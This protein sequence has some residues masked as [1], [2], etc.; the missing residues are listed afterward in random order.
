MAGSPVTI[1]VPTLHSVPSKRKTEKIVEVIHKMFLLLRK[2]VPVRCQDITIYFSMEEWQYI[3]AHKDLYKG[4]MMENQTSRTSQDGS[5]NEIPP[6]RCVGP[7]YSLDCQQ[8][9]PTIPHHYQSEESKDIKLE[10]KMEEADMYQ[11][12]DQQSTE[13]DNTMVNVKL[14]EMYTD[15]SVDPINVQVRSERQISQIKDQHLLCAE[16][17]ISAQRMDHMSEKILHLILEI[18]CLLTGESFPSVMAGNHLTIMVP[19]LDLLPSERKIEKILEVFHKILLLLKGEVPVRCQDIAI[20][21]SMEE[22]QYIEAHEDLYKSA[23]MENQTFLTLQNAFSSRNP[24][25]TCAGPLYSQHCAQE[26]HHYQGEDLK[27]IKLECKTEEAEM[28]VKDDQ[29]QQQSTEEGN[30]IVNVKLEEMPTNI[31]VVPRENIE[32]SVDSLKWRASSPDSVVKSEVQE[33][34]SRIPD[35]PNTLPSPHEV[36]P[37]KPCFGNSHPDTSNVVLDL[38]IAERSPAAHSTSKDKPPI[39]SSSSK[40]LSTKDGEQKTFLCSVCGKCIKTKGTLDRHMRFHT[41]RNLYPCTDCDR[42][43]VSLSLLNRHCRSHTGERPFSCP[44]CGKSYATNYKLTAHRRFHTGEELHTCSECGKQF[45]E[46]SLL[47]AHQKYH[48]AIKPHK[49]PECGRGYVFKSQLIQHQRVHTGEKLHKEK[50]HVCHECGKRF[51]QKFQLVSHQTQHA[52]ANQTQQA[53]AKLHVC[54]QCGKHFFGSSQLS[55]HKKTH[56]DGKPYACSECDKSFAYKAELVVHQNFHTGK[57][58]FSCLECGN[59][60]AFKSE[61][62]RHMQIHTG[63]RQHTCPECG[64]GFTWKSG[65]DVHLRCHQ[66]VKPFSCPECG[67][68]FVEKAKLNKHR[69]VHTGKPFLCST[70]GT[71]FTSQAQL[72]RHKATHA[73]KQPEGEKTPVDNKELGPHEVPSVKCTCFQCGRSFTQRS[74]LKSHLR[75]HTGER[76]FSCSECGKC[77]RTNC[78]LSAHVQLKSCGKNLTCPDCGRSFKKKVTFLSHLKVHTGELTIICKECGA[79]FSSN[80]GLQR[81]L[82]SHTGKKPFACTECDFS[83]IRRFKLTLHLQTHKSSHPEGEK[84]PVD[85]K[86]L[87]KFTCPECDSSFVHKSTLKTHL[88]IHTGEKAFACTECDYRC[89]RNNDLNRHL[90]THTGERP[91]FCSGC[92][93]TFLRKYKLK[94]HQKECEGE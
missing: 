22:W 42:K 69:I 21:F 7:L 86:E 32:Q 20:Y 85:K 3:E 17:L 83:C 48:L 94:M 2:E 78:R 75:T 60:Y 54:P 92:G 18:V 84:T 26:D 6:E 36:K 28:Y 19:P 1:M 61:L 31:S 67:K 29:H 63:Q 47:F 5:S 88:K 12:N 72:N 82:S 8:E 89:I 45:A 4:A 87:P 58:T 33:S 14:E 23:M 35:T 13:E 38:H 59:C 40:K 51:T 56:A 66:G 68:K 64:K 39:G 50:L 16:T 93:R 73:E 79:G 55:A 76:P 37:E 25:E 91:F 49:C 74:I 24:P 57:E 15:I 77:F 53:D 90:R 71:S 9:D 62:K 30:M 65:L 34:A 10:C 81:H 70:C 44:D 52:D 80:Q 41:G 46:K 27:D 43:F 11:K